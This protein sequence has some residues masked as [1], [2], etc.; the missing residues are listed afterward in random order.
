MAKKP[1]IE[2][3]SKVGFT[4][5]A[6]GLMEN[7]F[8]SF[9]IK[10]PGSLHEMMGVTKEQFKWLLEKEN[11]IKTD[12]TILERYPDI[13]KKDFFTLISFSDYTRNYDAYMVCKKHTTLYKIRKYLSLQEKDIRFYMDY[14]TMSEELG[15]NLKKSFHLFPKNLKE[16]H[17]QRVEEQ[18]L[19]K[20][21]LDQ[22]R[23]EAYN[24]ELKKFQEEN[25]KALE[26][27]ACF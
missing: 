16:R 2:Q 1:Y 20:E 15:Y 6:M 25:K 24:A 4:N 13:S 11:P 18:K 22:E 3:F 9:S 7:Y 27:G 8:N 26:A 21:K 19:L 10:K 12:L 17:D 23:L 5:L 14:L